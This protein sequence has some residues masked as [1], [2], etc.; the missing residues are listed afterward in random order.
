MKWVLTQHDDRAVARLRDEVGVSPLIATLLANRGI[1]DPGAARLFLANSLSDL[2]DPRVFLQMDRASARI[3]D[4]IARRE[5]ITV[6]GDYDVDGVS[7]SALL[8]LALRELGAETDWYIPDRLTEGYGLNP[9]ALDRIKAAGG[10]LVIT[11]DCGIS[12]LDAA[13]HARSIGLD[14][15]VT[16]HHEF[17]GNADGGGDKRPLPVAEAVLHPCL[18]HPDADAGIAERVG[19]ITGVGVAFKLAHALAGSGAIDQRLAGFLDLATLGTVAD[20]G[21]LTGENR[22]LVRHGL[23]ALSSPAGRPGIA[24]L[25]R[26]AGLNGKRITAGTVGFSLAPRINASGRMERADSAFRLLTTGSA[27]EAGRLAQALDDAN[28]E[29]QAVEERITGEAR[30]MCGAMEMGRTGA[31]VLAN[32]GWHPGVIGIVASR[33]VEE[34]YRP[35]ALIS[36]K[37][38]IGK[39]SARSIHGFDLY[40]GMRECAD[41]LL[42]FGGHKY[43]AG[44]SIAE[45]RIPAFRERLDGIVRRDVGPEGFERTVMV[46][47]PVKLAELTIELVRGLE[48]LEPFGRGNPEP[49]LGARDLAVLSARTVGNNHLKMRLR[50]ECGMPFDAIAFNR[51]GRPDC[52]GRDRIAAVFTPRISTWN[53]ATGIELEIKD[54]KP[55]R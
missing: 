18:L 43:A 21:R 47:G 32:E 26:V 40:R 4:A 48:Q 12:A 36:L 23:D 1:E 3:K 11:V 53:G 37:D 33:V 9:T 7:G 50:Q 10:G 20:M 14:L 24:A 44:F 30:G 52:A 29:R 54:L 22:I 13:L 19:V 41:L 5:R 38:G 46:D 17:A 6:Y 2:S 39:G 51:A 25:K 42:G 49:R 27:D 16:D 55:E 28:R 8:F 35:T 31:I 45:D 15:I 34:F